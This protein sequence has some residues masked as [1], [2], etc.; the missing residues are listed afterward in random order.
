[1]AEPTDILKDLPR[2]MTRSGII[3]QPSGLPVEIWHII[4][5]YIDEPRALF[6]CTLTCKLMA[7]RIFQLLADAVSKYPRGPDGLLD[8]RRMYHY[9]RLNPLVCY[10]LTSLCVPAD[11]VAKFICEC[12]GKLRVLDRLEFRQTAGRGPEALRPLRPFLLKAASRFSKLTSLHLYCVIFHSHG[13]FARLICGFP[14]LHTLTT[15]NISWKRGDRRDLAEE[16]FARYLHLQDITIYSD[17]LSAYTS[18]LAVSKISGKIA[19]LKLHG[20]AS[21]DPSSALVP[22]AVEV[23]VN[24]AAEGDTVALPPHKQVPEPRLPRLKCT[25]LAARVFVRRGCDRVWL[26]SCFDSLDA[27]F[28]SPYACL[29]AVRVTMV[30][31]PDKVA[32]MFNSEPLPFSK[33]RLRDILEVRGYICTRQGGP[34]STVDLV[35]LIKHGKQRSLAADRGHH[36]AG[37]TR[38]AHVQDDLQLFVAKL[39]PDGLLFP[40]PAQPRRDL[41]RPA[42]STAHER[43]EVRRRV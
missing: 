37:S 15:V 36:M 38:S 26:Q 34:W 28:F 27:L 33:L 29:K 13:D 42:G 8:V 11:C 25:G 35:D 2:W 18:L 21:L 41:L 3:L 5:S 23:H 39:F 31:H 9:M 40:P 24:S 30:E 14:A 6:A 22:P 17:R 20:P 1:M 12:A 43:Q 16:P 10:I 7:A 32:R 19:T 4:L